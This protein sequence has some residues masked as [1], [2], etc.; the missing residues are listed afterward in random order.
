MSHLD[1][2]AYFSRIGYQGSREPTFATL[3]S[4]HEHQVRSIPF[5]N[6]DVLWNRPVEIDLVSIQR[7]LIQKKRGGYCFE[8][9]MI[10]QAVL[11]ELGF[12]VKARAARG[13]YRVPSGVTRPRTHMVL[14][15]HLPDGDYLADCGFGGC[16]LPEPLRF[17]MGVDQKTSHGLYR[18]NSLE[19]E[20]EI[21]AVVGS[22]WERLYRIASSEQAFEDFVLQNWYISTHPQSHFR[23]NLMVARVAETGRYALLNLDWSFY[24]LDG[25]IEKKT[26][27]STA[28]LCDVLE[29]D[30]LLPLTDEK[31]LLDL[32]SFVQR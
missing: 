13:F 29:R 21:E 27:S 8:Q 24:S 14:R 31:D 22:Q 16:S 23:P 19:D 30:F 3:K 2:A 12:S 7:K 18:M 6:L 28:E 17:E 32:E 4:I 10:L 26:L 25:T 1:L 15:V 9:N 5:E 20:I 11:R